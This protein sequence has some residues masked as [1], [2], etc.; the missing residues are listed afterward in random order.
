MDLTKPPFTAFSQWVRNSTAPRLALLK[1][2]LPL[3]AGG[4]DL[5][6][7]VQDRTLRLDVGD[8]DVEDVVAVPGR[9]LRMTYVD[10]RMEPS[11]HAGWPSVCPTTDPVPWTLMKQ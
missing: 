10:D 6:H 2:G 3:S 7:G 9:T 1:G 5:I 4:I 11:L 8:E